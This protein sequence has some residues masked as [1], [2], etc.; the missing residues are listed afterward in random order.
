MPLPVPHVVI[1]RIKRIISEHDVVLFMNG[2]AAFPQCSASA[3]IVQVLSQLKVP[4]RDINVLKDRDIDQG[5]KAFAEWVN[6]Y[7]GVTH[8]YLRDNPYNM[9]FTFIAPS[10]E[11]IQERLKE[12]SQATGITDILNLPATRVFKIR[13]HFDV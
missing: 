13:A 2:E 8:N 6:R 12:I 4:F 10:V 1:E 3:L 5:I 11:E 7:P 9:W